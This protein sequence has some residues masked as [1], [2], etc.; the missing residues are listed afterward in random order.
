MSVERLPYAQLDRA[1]AAV[2]QRRRRDRVLR[3]TRAAHA[4]L[5]QLAGLLIVATVVVTVVL[6]LTG[7]L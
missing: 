6:R 3:R 7:E 5:E 2:A 4:V 1:P